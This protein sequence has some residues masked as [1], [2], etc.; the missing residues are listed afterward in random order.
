MSWAA[1]LGLAAGAYAFKVFGLM[2]MGPRSSSARA[3]R[4]VAL[5]PPALLC[6]LIAVQT[7]GA[8]RALTI[9]ARTAGVTVGAV[10]AWKRAPFVVVIVVAAAVTA[11]VRALS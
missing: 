6:A 1:I 7:F 3:L 5:L 2:A 10:A 11:A 8:E 9:D 4:A